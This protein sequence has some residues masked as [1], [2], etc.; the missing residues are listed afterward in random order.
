MSCGTCSAKSAAIAKVKVY[1]PNTPQLDEGSCD[2]TMETMLEWRL[3]LL[4]AKQKGLQSEIG[5][6]TAQLNSALGIVIS[7]INTGVVC[8]F[9]KYF[10][11]IQSIVVQIINSNQ[12]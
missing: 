7:A 3:K 1:S 9:A 8:R 5:F 4:C 10:T 6:T 2:Y 12:C 11:S